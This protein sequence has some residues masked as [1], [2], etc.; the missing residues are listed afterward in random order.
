MVSRHTWC[1]VYSNSLGN[2]AFF[3]Q[4]IPKQDTLQGKRILRHGGFSVNNA[5]L[6]R[7][8]ALH[9][10]LPF[11]LA[12]LALMHLIALHDTAGLLFTG[13][14][15]I[16]MKSSSTLLKASLSFILP[17]IKPAPYVISVLVGS[18]LGYGFGEREKSGG[19][20]FRFRQSIVLKDYLFWLH[21]FLYTRGYCFN[22]LP[23][24]YTPGE[25]VLEYYRFGT[26][27]FTSLL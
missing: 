13:P 10:V 12:A 6:N 20:R 1:K 7:F 3:I 9:F 16:Y 14:K 17:N 8:F 15:F 5:T 19:V 27:K 23:V 25:K 21:N 2:K 11:I 18:L 26:Y 4:L 22:L 24:I